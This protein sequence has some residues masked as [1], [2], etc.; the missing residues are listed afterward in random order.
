MTVALA[1]G[2]YPSGSGS[3]SKCAQPARL[4][5]LK[6]AVTCYYDLSSSRCIAAHDATMGPESARPCV[7]HGFPRCAEYALPCHEHGRPV[8]P[9]GGGRTASSR[10]LP[11]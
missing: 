7:V 6:P 3:V 4:S 5:A 8:V 10:K 1:A 9:S 2:G 11:G